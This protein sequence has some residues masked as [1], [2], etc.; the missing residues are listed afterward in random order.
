VCLLLVAGL[1]VDASLVVRRARAQSMVSAPMGAHAGL[2]RLPGGN[3]T[4]ATR[5]AHA[6]RTLHIFIVPSI[7]A[8]AGHLNF[9]GSALCRIPAAQAKGERNPFSARAPP[10]A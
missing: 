9:V 8:T 2:Y 4:R 5:R 10:A 7:Y 6:G 3:F 1:R